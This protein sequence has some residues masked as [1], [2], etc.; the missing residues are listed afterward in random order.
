MP[1]DR[2]VT[3]SAP[4]HQFMA[5]AL[6]QAEQ[7]LYSVDPNPRVGCVLVKQGKLLGRG[8]HRSAGEAHAEVNALRNATGLG[9]DVQGAECYVTLEPCSHYGRTGPCAKAL[10]DAGIARVV[11]AVADPN[12]QVAGRGIRLL[13]EAGVRVETGCLQAEAEAL[14]AGFLKRMRIG[15][16]LVRLKMGVSL[17]GRIAL[18]NGS[19]QWITGPSARLDVHKLRARSSV[20]LTGSGTLIADDPQLTVRSEYVVSQSHGAPRQPCRA[21]LDSKGRSNPE[22]ALF[23]ASHPP[24]QQSPVY[25]FTLEQGY[26]HLQGKNFL[27]HVQVFKTAAAG[28][29]IDLR[30]VLAMLAQL[31]CNEVLVEA[32]ATLAG[33]FIRQGL[34]DELWLYQSTSLLGNASQGAFDLGVYTALQDAPDMALKDLRQI[35][36]DIRIVLEPRNSAE[37]AELI[38]N[39]EQIG[40]S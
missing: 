15:L 25:I 5:M 1:G 32:G 37:G 23:S 39:A 40:N 24:C 38:Q 27:Q 13:Q 10:V 14:N 7:G 19:S 35:G 11:V 29:L 18:A 26:C 17:D 3:F 36:E 34:V 9:E 33:A 6:Q 20:V 2:A 22:Q 31:E 30:A 28:D 21:L 12:P 16:P 8:W 4:D